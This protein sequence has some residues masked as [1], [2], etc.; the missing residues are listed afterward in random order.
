MTG[1]WDL[2]GDFDLETYHN[3]EVNVNQQS[4]KSRIKDAVIV[5]S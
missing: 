3:F 1:Q 2:S 4:Y 5:G